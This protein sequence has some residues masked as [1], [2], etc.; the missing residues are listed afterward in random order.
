MTTASVWH[1]IS[2]APHDGT[3]IL[4]F[5]KAY[6]YIGIG[7]YSDGHIWTGGV[8]EVP[9]AIPREWEDVATHWMPLPVKPESLKDTPAP[10]THMRWLPIALADKAITNVEDFSEVGIT[11]RTSD[12]YW[13]RDDDGRIYEAAWSEGDRNYWWDFAGES[14]VDPVEF[15]PHPLDPRWT[16]TTEG[17]P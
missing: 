4:Y 8:V 17:Q 13:V 3:S 6:S 12:R 15:M 5:S 7:R 11:L 16:A 1:P 10:T 9:S 2:T 14:P